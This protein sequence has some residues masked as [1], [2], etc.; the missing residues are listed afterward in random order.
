MCQQYYQEKS[1]CD[2]SIK[3]LEWIW[4]EQMDDIF[5]KTTKDDGV[6]WGMD[7]EKDINTQV[8]LQ[9]VNDHNNSNTNLTSP[10]FQIPTFGTTLKKPFFHLDL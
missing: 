9:E 4:Y 2:T 10:T 3:A 1:V 8:N 6:P 5:A 7:M